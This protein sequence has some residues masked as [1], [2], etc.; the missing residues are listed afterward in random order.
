MR[1]PAHGEGNC[2]G[3]LCHNQEGILLQTALAAWPSLA[4]RASNVEKLSVSMKASFL[5]EF[6]QGQESDLVGMSG[7]S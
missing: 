3:S 7:T 5:P 1:D 4:L 6:M 2:R